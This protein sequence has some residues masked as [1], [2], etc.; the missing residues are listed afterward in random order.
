MKNIYTKV[1]TSIISRSPLSGICSYDKRQTPDKNA[2]GINKGFTLIELLVVVL[3]I[4]ILAAVALP[5]YQKAVEKSKATQALSLIKSIRQAA[6]AYYL[7]N[8][9]YATSFDELSVEIPWTGTAKWRGDA[10]AKDTRSNEDWSLQFYQESGYSPTIRIGRLRG[11]WAGAGFSM[12]I[13]TGKLE[14]IELTGC[15]QDAKYTATAGE[16]CA[17]FFGGYNEKTWGSCGRT[18]DLS[19]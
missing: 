19:N 6:A 17:K 18:Y 16:Y 9:N 14:C 4:G 12:S 10:T 1:P 13:E 15:G 11:K 5:Q 8:G 3:I 2:R 7:S